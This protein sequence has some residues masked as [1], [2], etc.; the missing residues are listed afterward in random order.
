MKTELKIKGISFERYMENDIM[1][2]SI[3]LHL[4]GEI[5][6]FGLGAKEI[7][8]LLKKYRNTVG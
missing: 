7:R 5:P 4:E 3:E 8:K 1:R 6:N 2:H